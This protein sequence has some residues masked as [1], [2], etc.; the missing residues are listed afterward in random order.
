MAAT[1]QGGAHGHEVGD[2]VLAIANQLVQNAGDQSE[3]FGMVETDAASQAS[4]GKEARL[5]DDELVKL[6]RRRQSCLISLRNI[7]PRIVQETK[8]K[9]KTNL[10][11][12]QLHD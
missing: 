6:W 12:S 10:F 8:H 4:L 3:G 1:Q 5:G 2:R 7:H 11:R 9:M